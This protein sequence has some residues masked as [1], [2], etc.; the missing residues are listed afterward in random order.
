MQLIGKVE[1]IAYD[2]DGNVTDHRKINNLVLDSGRNYITA[3]LGDLSVP[4]RTLTK[5]GIGS[6]NTAANAATQSGL[7]TGIDI[8]TGVP[9]QTTTSV[10]NDTLSL[11]VTFNFDSSNTIRE[12]CLMTNQAILFSQP[13][14]GVTRVVVSPAI[15]VTTG[16]ALTATWTLQ[17]A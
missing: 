2:K 10:S 4:N 1:L 9:T 16:S 3:L 13:L 6:D 8:Q 7:I 15:S 14:E 11:Q 17:V 12:S 5:I